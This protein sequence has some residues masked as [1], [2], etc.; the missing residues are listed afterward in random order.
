MRTSR[1]LSIAAAAALTVTTTAASGHPAAATQPGQAC[2]SWQLVPAP[3]ALGGEASLGSVIPVSAGDVMFTGDITPSASGLDGPWPV[4]GPLVL[5][6]DGRSVTEGAQ[7]PADFARYLLADANTTGWIS[8]FDSA[9]DG[10]AFSAANITADSYTNATAEHWHDGHWTL[11][12]LQPTPQ[13]KFPSG[14]PA[15][16]IVRATAAFSPDDAW[17]VGELGLYT[18]GL[19]E[20]KDIVDSPFIEHWDGTQWQVV[21]AAAPALPAGDLLGI[22]AIS[23]EDI[24]AVG[25]QYVPGNGGSAAEPL[26]EHWNGTAWATVPA[27]ASGQQGSYLWAVSAVS[28][29]DV[30]AVGAQNGYPGSAPLIEHWNGG[31]WTIQQIPDNGEVLTS[32]Y[33]ASPSDVWALGQQGTQFADDIGQQEYQSVFLHWDGTAWTTVPL[34]GPQEYGLTEQYTAIAGTGPGDVWAAGAALDNGNGGN[35]PLIAH[36]GCQ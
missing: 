1:V 17:A 22:A 31:A 9:A 21:T 7:I 23:P 32:V 24:W 6:W 12:P 28:S 15:T 20:V 5:R 35:D 26:I 27:P 13:A 8:A 34:P 16:Q 14:V 10:W 2:A 18:L 30:W 3:A 25:V 29:D 36:L 4:S 19:E 33:A 11:T